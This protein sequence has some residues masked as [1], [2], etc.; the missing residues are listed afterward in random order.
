MNQRLTI[1]ATAVLM[2]VAACGESPT[3]VPDTPLAPSLD[4]LVITQGVPAP[5]GPRAKRPSLS[6][7]ASAAASLGG[8]STTPLSLTPQ[9]C[10]ATASQQVVVTYSVTGRQNSAASFQVNTHWAYNGS[11]WSGS[12]PQTVNV[13]AKPP[14]T[15]DT[16]QVTVTVANASA[17]AA[18]TSSFTIQP[19]NLI[20]TP[21]MALSLTSA[22]AHPN[23]TVFV[24][25]GPC[26]V[27]NTAPTLVVPNDMTVEAS[28][29]AGAT[30]SFTVTATDLEDNDL[31]SSVTCTPASGTTFPLGTT[32]VNCSVTD[33]GG[34]TTTGSFNITVV[35]TTPAFFTSFPTG[36]VNLIAADIHGAV[37]NIDALGI[38]VEDVGHVSEPSTFHCDYVTGTVLAIG[39]TTPVS[40]TAK[41][42]IGNESVANTFDVFV[43]LNVDATGFLLPLRMIAPFSAHKRGSTVPH[44]FLPPTYADGTPATDLE[45]GLRLV[46]TRLDGTPDPAGIEGND[47]AAGSTAWRYDPDGGQYIFNLKTGTATPW[48]LGTWGTTVS[49]AGITL[50]MTQFELRR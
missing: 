22:A 30:V 18:G 29:S 17:T 38:T 11:T 27:T 16:Y 9:T 2:I 50:A 10:S 43:G 36:T 15:T 40:C 5:V 42:A 24:A 4:E 12:V 13:A 33:G 23:V 3:S 46:L 47:Y 41:D 8:S 28:S 7:V 44:K 48:D 26:A 6:E 37:L 49:Y 14:G 1:V 39:G 34:L 35:D 25:F 21:P 20:T 31:T 32:T 45:D 19:F